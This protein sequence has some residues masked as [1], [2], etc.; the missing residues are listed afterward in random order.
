MVLAIIL[1][2]LAV[3]GFLILGWVILCERMNAFL[4]HFYRE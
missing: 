3:F 2:S 4:P 1:V